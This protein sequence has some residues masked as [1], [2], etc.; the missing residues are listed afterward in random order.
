MKLTVSVFFP[1]QGGRGNSLLCIFCNS[2][3]TYEDYLRHIQ[4]HVDAIIATLGCYAGAYCSGAAEEP[5]NQSKTF[6]F[7]TTTPAV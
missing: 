1:G 3:F 4:P 6:E 5:I 2:P 7:G